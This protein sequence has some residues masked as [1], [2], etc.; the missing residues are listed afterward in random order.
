MKPKI[1]I[2]VP[3]RGDRPKLLEN[4]WRQIWAQTIKPTKVILVNDPAISADA[5]ITWRYRKGYDALRGEEI[6]IIFFMEND[7]WYAPNYLETM[8]AEWE[9]QGRPDMMGTIYTIYY[10][11]RLFAY[12]TMHH[13]TR[14][15]AMSTMIKPNL[16]I[17]W[18]SD[19]NPFTDLWLWQHL[20]VKKH[21]F[22]PDNHICM[23][24]KHGDGLCG[25]NSH[26][27]QLHRYTDGKGTPDPD[28]SFLK[29]VLDPEG[30]EFFS[31]YFNHANAS[32]S[33]NL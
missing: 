2:I 15:S 25:G 18:C 13:H 24:M 14:S 3:D 23:G 16:E 7:D 19:N 33:E 22:K 10:H 20:Q 8:L 29:S 1:G 21:L 12:F 26:T 31:N 6:D 4:C 17:A 28:K 11:I 32:S 9:K 27:D 5:D 30:F